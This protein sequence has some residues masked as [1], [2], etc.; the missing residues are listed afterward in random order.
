MAKARGLAIIARKGG[1]EPFRH[2][3]PGACKAPGVSFLR[4][5]GISAV[6]RARQIDSGK[7]RDTHAARPGI[8]ERRMAGAS[9]RAAGK[10]IIHQH[11]IA[12]RDP[13]AAA[14]MG[15]NRPCQRPF[16]RL[17]AQPAQARRA[18]TAQQAV[19]Q[20]LPFARLRQLARQQ[21]RL[22][23]PAAPQPPAMEGHRNQQW[24]MPG[25]ERIGQPR[26]DQP[27]Q[28]PRMG[29]PP[30]MLVIKHKLPRGIIVKRR[31]VNRHPPCLRHRQRACLVASGN[32]EQAPAFGA[33]AILSG[34][35]R[36]A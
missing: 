35:C 33:Q 29:D 4:A 16:T 20:C 25:R 15:D 14:G 26:R 36:T 32:V 8:Q 30:A 23:E 28:Q 34:Q 22:I 3:A 18:S 13:R 31:S 17:A 21:C 24:R 1:S 6:T 11:H 12:P 2:A 10:D 7:A 9:S 19:D 5:S 27:R